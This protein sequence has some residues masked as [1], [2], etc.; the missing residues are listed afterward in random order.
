[1]RCVYPDTW[2]GGPGMEAPLVVIGDIIVTQSW[3][4]TPSGTVPVGS[5]T[6]TFTD[7]SIT[8]EAIPAWAIVCA[9]LFAVLCLLGL[10]FLL[11]K[12]SRTR[13]GV[14]VVVQGPGLLH[15]TQ[16]PVWALDQVYDLNARVNYARSLT[17]AGR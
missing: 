14:Q 2:Q 7:M 3:V 11:V 17:A 15:A 16:I 13:G 4:V 6:W 5:V 10:L 1:M 12:E 9:V 8:S